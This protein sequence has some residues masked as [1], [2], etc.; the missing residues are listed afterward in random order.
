MKNVVTTKTIY[1]LSSA[2]FIWGIFGLLDIKNEVYSGFNQNNFEIVSIE[3][4]SPAA[5]AGLQVGDILLSS[6]GIAME[7]YKE[8]DKR[9]REKVG[10]ERTYVVKRDGVEQTIVLTYAGLP[11][12]NKTNRYISFVIG[13][14]F[15]LLPSVLTANNPSE[16]KVPL[17]LSMTT[18]GFLFLNGPYF[19]N[20]ALRDFVEILGIAIITFALTYLADY[21]LKYSPES[22]I[23]T[24]KGYGLMF[25]PMLLIVAIVLVL[26]VIKPDYSASLNGFIQGI[27][28]L[29]FLGYLATSIITL[30]RKFVRT[31]PALRKSHGLD[32]ML[33]GVCFSLLPLFILFTINTINPGAEVPGEDYIF[34]GFALIP[35]TFSVALNRY[36]KAT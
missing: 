15:I 27:F 14:L 24:K 23:T 7:N 30:I 25:A 19:T 11:Q 36:V 6:D 33:L 29:F 22:K 32:L 34:F 13:L 26:T 10:Q 1:V 3:E 12:K 4:D 2:F 5:R 20:D 35:I 9:P 17:G 31:E 18:F 28:T 21:L 8:R 16:L